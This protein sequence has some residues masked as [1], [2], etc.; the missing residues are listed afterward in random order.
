MG[1]GDDGEGARV[2]G[3]LALF[4]ERSLLRKVALAFVERHG[5]VV[6]FRDADLVGR[7]LDSKASARTGKDPAQRGALGK[8][9]V[10]RESAVK[11]RGQILVK[12][13][14]RDFIGTAPAGTGGSIRDEA[15]SVGGRRRGCWRR[16]ERNRLLRG[17]ACGYS[18]RREEHNPSHG[19]DYPRQRACAVKRGG[20]LR[21]TDFVNRSVLRGQVRA[22]RPAL[23]PVRRP[24][25]QTWRGVD[26]S[27]STGAFRR[28]F[29]R[30]D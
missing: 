16:R 25:V 9:G 1:I 30:A 22:W 14:A 28:E 12:I 19:L 24:A 27:V 21:E 2:A 23:Q 3:V 15:E 20:E 11:E 18:Q 13:F 7:K 17:G 5:I 26:Q 4:G 29:R 6:A 8:G 10:E